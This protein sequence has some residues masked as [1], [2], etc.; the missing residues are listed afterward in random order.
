MPR[1]NARPGRF[2]LLVFVVGIGVAGAIAGIVWI[3]GARSQ[4]PAPAQSAALPAT[5]V[6]ADKPVT[7]TPAAAV[8]AQDE[9]APAAALP[10]GDYTK[11]L[12]AV[13]ALE[14]DADFYKALTLI[15]KLQKE[16]ASDAQK[17]TDLRRLE[18]QLQKERIQ[19]A[20][21][22]EALGRL[23]S[24]NDAVRSEARKK[25]E[26]AGEG[27][28]ILLYKVLTKG[29][30][31]AAVKAAAETLLAF[32]D[33]QAPAEIAGRVT[34]TPDAPVAALLLAA[35]TQAVREAPAAYRQAFAEAFGR[36]H[37]LVKADT[38][39]VRRAAADVLL[40][41]LGEWLRGAA[42]ELDGFLALKGAHADLQQYVKRG[43]Q[44]P[45]P[46]LQAWAQERAILLQLVDAHQVAWWRFDEADGTAARDSA[47]Q[48]LHGALRGAPK[49][50]PGRMGNALSLDGENDFVEVP[51]A[52][53]LDVGAGGT[54]FAVTFWLFLRR[55][56]TGQWRNI[57]HKG[58]RDEERTFAL[59]LYPDRNAIHFR[60]STDANGNEGGD[61]AS[62]VELNAW[63]HVAYVKEGKSLKLYLNGKLDAEV[64]LA[65]TV[66]ANTG[67][68]YLG[69]DPW[70][71]GI[72][73]A[74]DDVRVY[75]AAL[76]PAKIE[77]LARQGQ[78]GAG[79]GMHM[80][81]AREDGIF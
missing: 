24:E 22:A 69:K 52:K 31:P 60:I 35:L 25:I 59:W 70:Y 23:A 6:A 63:T 17:Q 42:D 3:A 14:E 50:T 45:D 38:A 30:E 62:T 68:L 61:S 32:Q 15:W 44:S 67:S 40:V 1:V 54:D 26:A 7:Q 2:F 43:L 37:A 81:R 18:R 20:N 12:Q 49:R 55:D 78:A 48:N 66:V 75:S 33:P 65:G 57:M 56:A 10:S 41:A 73:G 9:P 16:W 28:R 13:R 77:M 64:A 72:D 58:T 71:G 80:A 5:A 4:L 51:Q 46:A 29:Q 36:L 34:A 79:G 8:A 47:G 27:G 74:L 39:G 11:Q 53:A 21:L 76:A 19:T